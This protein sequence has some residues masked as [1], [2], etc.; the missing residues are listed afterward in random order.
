MNC[1]FDD[2]QP[3]IS[4]YREAEYGHGQFSIVNASHGVWT[5]HKNSRDIGVASDTVSITTLAS[6]PA[7]KPMN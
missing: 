6:I 4:A 2:P 7:C 1:R 3:K 5:W